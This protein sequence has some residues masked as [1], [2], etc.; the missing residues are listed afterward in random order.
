[1]PLR[2]LRADLSLDGRHLEF[3]NLVGQFEGGEA[4]GSLSAE[5]LAAPE[6]RGVFEFSEVNLRAL[7]AEFP[8]LADLFD[9]VATAKIGFTTRGT[10]RS[11]LI[12]SLDCRGTAHVTKGLI[13]GINLSDLP[14]TSRSD[15]PEQAAVPDPA[16][17]VGLKTSFSDAGASFVCAN[18]KIEFQNLLLR[19]AKSDW[20]GTGTVDFSHNL[21]LRF[22]RAFPGDGPRRLVKA[23]DA[24]AD[25]Y[26][27]TGS[28]ASPRVEMLAAPHP[29]DKH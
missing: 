6:Y 2:H 13:A 4:D 9:G 20:N 10:N 17:D 14:N 22:V 27:V 3:S 25:E 24:A 29:E 26:R 23:A 18:S 19:G 15:E 8:S 16:T 5:F 21:D 11:D 1:M 28:L 7:S 12:A